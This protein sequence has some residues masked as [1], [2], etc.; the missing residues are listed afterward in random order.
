MEKNNTIINSLKRLERAGEENSRVTEKLK[1]SCEEIADKILKMFPDIED[2]GYS[3]GEY[4][5]GSKIIS[6]NLAIIQ[7]YKNNCGECLHVVFRDEFQEEQ[8]GAIELY[9]LNIANSITRERALRFA[10]IIAEGELDRIAE[11]LESENST[12][13]TAIKILENDEK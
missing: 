3:A 8:Y 7:Y 2:H 6:D 11:K 9:T 12:S 13:Q 4:P 5:V 1:N 10:K